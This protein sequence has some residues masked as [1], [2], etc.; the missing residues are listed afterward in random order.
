MS[1][2]FSLLTTVGKRPAGFSGQRRRSGP[3]IALGYL[4]VYSSVRRVLASYAES[5][6]YVLQ[7]SWGESGNIRS[8]VQGYPQYII[9][10][11]LTWNPEDRN[12]DKQSKSTKTLLLVTGPGSFSS[13]QVPSAFLRC[14]LF[15]FL[16]SLYSG[17]ALNSVFGLLVMAN[18]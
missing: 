12:Q 15:R 13:E 14:L 5:L 16:S 7:Y 17:P 8:K 11:R 6:G 10:S 1:L 4:R 18:G 9:S 3:L 2:Y